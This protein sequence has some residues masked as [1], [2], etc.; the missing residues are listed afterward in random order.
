MDARE[1]RSEE[2]AAE[3]DWE[4]QRD[5]DA[6]R[7]V[8][9]GP[10]DR[11][12]RRDRGKESRGDRGTDTGRRVRTR[13]VGGA[14]PGGGGEAR[15]PQAQ[16]RGFHRDPLAVPP[17]PSSLAVCRG[18]QK[19]WRH[20]LSSA[21]SEAL[22]PMLCSKQGQGEGSA[23]SSRLPE[24][25][26]D[27]TGARAGRGPVGTSG[28]SPSLLKFPCPLHIENTQVFKG[29]LGASFTHPHLRPSVSIPVKTPG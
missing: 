3:G 25:S 2:G 4:R 22:P 27:Q 15:R 16:P 23:R 14:D 7:A 21:S 28:F 9:D 1:R 10:S 20:C 18:F 6:W 13:D 8:D 11:T 12:G 24:E 5:G 29:A 17:V 19:S 26:P